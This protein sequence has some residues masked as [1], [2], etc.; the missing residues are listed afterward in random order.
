MP[1]PGFNACGHG[2]SAGRT[3]A[4]GVLAADPAKTA[5]SARD[6]TIDGSFFQ[7]LTFLNRCRHV[8][9]ISPAT[10]APS[11]AMVDGSGTTL[12]TRSLP[13]TASV[14]GR[15]SI[16]PLVF[17]PRLPL[18]D[19]KRDQVVAARP[20]VGRRHEIEIGELLA[21]EGQAAGR[22]HAARRRRIE[23]IIHHRSRCQDQAAADVQRAQRIARGEIPACIDRDA[24]RWPVPP[25][26]PPLLT[27]TAELGS[28]PSTTSLPWL[29]VVGP[30]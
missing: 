7:G 2:T 30:V 11:S 12:T 4:A 1:S 26:V 9:P 19:P 18:L 21:V 23:F 20:E 16:V 8:Q 15:P 25:K 28:Q 27:L 3:S 13:C 29:M 5:S 22:N 10:P 24:A 6:I 17:A 14:A